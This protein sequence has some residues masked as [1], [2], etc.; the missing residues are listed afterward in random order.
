MT[1]LV[2]LYR[3][4]DDPE[5]FDRHF[6][7][8]HA[9]LAQRYPGLRRFE[10]TRITG[11]PIGDTKFYLMTEMLFDSKDAMETALASKEGKAVA[12]DLMGFAANL[13]TIFYGV[14]SDPEQRS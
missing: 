1:K 11:A 5:E 13:V 3:R 10:V 8:V 14:V 6:Y 7:S 12:R 2:A 9:L 4:P